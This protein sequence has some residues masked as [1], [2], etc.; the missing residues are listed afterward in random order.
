LENC[1]L[2]LS[3]KSAI[4]LTSY[5]TNAGFEKANP[6]RGGD[7]KSWV[8][9]VWDCQTAE[10]FLGGFFV[11][12]S[13]VQHDLPSAPAGQVFSIPERKAVIPGKNCRS[14]EKN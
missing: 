11:K 6:S 12:L 3:K 2:K 9:L 10:I 4:I 1:I 8:P 13:I 5:L 14:F 7:A